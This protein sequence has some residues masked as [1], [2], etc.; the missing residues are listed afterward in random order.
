MEAWSPSEEPQSGG[1]SL[2]RLP[3]AVPKSLLGGWRFH[4]CTRARELGKL[5]LLFA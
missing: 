4:P 3:L 1:P 5:D 2:G